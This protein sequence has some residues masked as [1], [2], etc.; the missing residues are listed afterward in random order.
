[1]SKREALGRMVRETWVEFAKT[2]PKPKPHHLAPWEE[3]DEPNKEVDRLIGER[4]RRATIAECVA[5]LE[6]TVPNAVVA[7]RYKISD[8][9][10]GM[11]DAIE[12]V[13]ELDH[14]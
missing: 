2:Q 1:M 3:L 6:A 8:W 7:E 11:L 14:E 9:A 12:I 13:R 10:R 4:L 5:A